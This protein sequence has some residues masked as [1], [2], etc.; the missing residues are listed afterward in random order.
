MGVVR[1]TIVPF[2]L[3]LVA[4]TFVGW[5][6][7]RACPE[8]TRLI[9]VFHRCLARPAADIGRTR[10]RSAREELQHHAIDLGRVLVRRPVAGP[11]DPVRVERTDGLADLAD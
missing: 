7:H 6:A 11:G 9:D 5:A 8:A 1:A 3:V 2:L 4:A 10:S